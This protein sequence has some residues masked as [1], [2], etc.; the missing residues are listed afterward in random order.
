MVIGRP[1]SVGVSG[2]GAGSGRWGLVGEGFEFDGGGGG[3]VWD[4]LCSI[5]LLFFRQ[6]LDFVVR[7]FR[8]SS[9]G[10]WL[11]GL[12]TDVLEGGQGCGFLHLLGLYFLMECVERSGEMVKRKLFTKIFMEVNIY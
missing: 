11:G 6:M 12:L 3:V 4:T 1:A 8:S 2:E 5:Q 7:G 9:E 10:W